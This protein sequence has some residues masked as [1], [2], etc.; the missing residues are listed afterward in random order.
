VKDN[1]NAQLARGGVLTAH[2]W[3]KGATMMAVGFG[4]REQNWIMWK[5][6]SIR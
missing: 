3:R 5:G 1:A 4:S 6:G 2:C